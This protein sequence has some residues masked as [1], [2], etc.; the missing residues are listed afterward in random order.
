MISRKT[1]NTP[2]LKVNTHRKSWQ[3][4]TSRMKSPILR[5]ASGDMNDFYSTKQLHSEFWSLPITSESTNFSTSLSSCDNIVLTSSMSTKDNLKMYKVRTAKT[6]DDTAQLIELQSIS[7]PGKGVSTSFLLPS[8]YTHAKQESQHDRLILSGHQDGLV[9]LIST[10]ET[11][12]DAKIIR[13]FNHAKYLKTTQPDTL[14]MWLKSKRSSPVK[15]VRAWDDRGFIS[16]INESLFIYDLNQHRIPLYL[17]S[18]SGLEGLD[19]NPQNPNLLSLVGSQFGSSGLSL[20]DLRGGGGHG[21]LYSPDAEMLGNCSV[22]TACAWLDEYTVANTIDNQVKV[23]DIRST[24]AKCTVNGHKGSIKGL[25]YHNDTRRLYSSDDEGYTIAWDLQGIDN[26]SECHLATGF[27]S[28][29][30]EKISEIKQC[31]NVVVA[32]KN[33]RTV[34]SIKEGQTESGGIS[35]FTFLETLNDGSLLTL[36]SKEIGLHSIVEIET[37]FVPPRNPDRQRRISDGENLE[38][39]ATLN[40]ESHNSHWEDASSDVTLDGE[41]FTTPI[42]EHFSPEFIYQNSHKVQNPSIYS[43][44]NMELSGSTIYN[45]RILH[46]DLTV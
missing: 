26:V 8:S 11:H 19:C 34:S 7:V 3:N 16:V 44:K 41:E 1:G 38:S 39:D 20:L 15:I 28:I 9:N 40:E 2:Q 10:S 37:P 13:R 36:D 4:D 24:G 25:K 35:S 42:K 31:G 46:D 12:G 29:T 22:S 45:D 14:D 27:L 43:L 17:Q 30:E 32:P 5:K 21:N 18:F 23:W 33:L 6:Q